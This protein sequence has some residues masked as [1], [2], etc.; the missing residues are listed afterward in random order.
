M[1]PISRIWIVYDSACGLC[2]AVRDWTTRQISLISVE[3]LAAGSE[4]ALKR[5]GQL[6]PGN[7]PRSP[8][9]AKSGSATTRGWSV[10][11]L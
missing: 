6:P 9:Q 1:Q 7:S 10:Y 11:G 8:I 2:S 4:Q 5:F 3:F